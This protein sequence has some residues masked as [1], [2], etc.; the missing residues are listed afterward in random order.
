MIAKITGD[1]GGSIYDGNWFDIADMSGLFVKDSKGGVF[2]NNTFNRCM[3]GQDENARES[4]GT[5]DPAFDAIIRLMD[6]HSFGFW[7]N[8]FGYVHGLPAGD[9]V[10][11]F[12]MTGC[13][14]IQIANNVFETPYER[15][16]DKDN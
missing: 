8:H 4:F 2:V 11:T 10:K 16:D 15:L 7:G 3:I 1:C 12:H 9:P 5:V 13:D 14:N 6:C